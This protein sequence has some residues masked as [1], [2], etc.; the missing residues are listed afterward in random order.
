M[1]DSLVIDVDKPTKDAFDVLPT[2]LERLIAREN[3][4]TANRVVLGARSR[5]HVRYGFLRDSIDW[6][7]GKNG[8][9]FVGI[10]RKAAYKI[11][12]TRRFNGRY[13]RAKPSNYAHLVERGTDH[14][15]AYP[16]MKPA[17]VSEQSSHEGR[18]MDAMIT[19]ANDAGLGD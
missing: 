8:D 5:V 6:V 9:I 19:A 16:F 13:D 17:V 3:E 10:D 14:S 15:P 1:S 11:P 2:A 4:T 18:I 12:G 7:Q